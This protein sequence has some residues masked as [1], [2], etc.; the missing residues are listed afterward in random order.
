MTQYQEAAGCQYQPRQCVLGIRRR[1]GSADS[2]AC[3]VDRLHAAV[4]KF[5]LERDGVGRTDFVERQVAGCERPGLR[6]QEVG[7][8]LRAENH[9]QVERGGLMDFHSEHVG[10]LH[11]VG[12]G[13]DDTLQQRRVAHYSCRECRIIHCTRRHVVAVNLDAVEVE[14]RTVIDCKVEFQFRACR[15][16]WKRKR[17]A[18]IISRWAE[19]QCRLAE[20]ITARQPAIASVIDRAFRRPEVERRFRLCGE[21]GDLRG[22][23]WLIPNRNVVDTACQEACAVAIPR[24]D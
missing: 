21:L 1:A 7:G 9:A 16:V 22:R 8:E 2:V 11:E 23:K 24:A 4:E 5:D 19:W 20:F 14:D 6:W 12:G 17:V 3:H 15:I 18:E 13:K 10:T